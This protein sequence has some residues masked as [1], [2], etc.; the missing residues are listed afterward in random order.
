MKRL[1]LILTV[2]A[3]LAG[4]WAGVS[5][6]MR[7]T[8]SPGTVLLIRPG[9]TTRQI[10]REL[11]AAG[12]I[13]SANGFRLVN[14]LEGRRTLKAGEYLFE[15]PASALEVY[16]RLARGDVMAAAVVIPEG[17]NQWDIAAALEQAGICRREEFLQVS[18]HD[19]SLV[20]DIDPQAKSL[21][22]YLFPDTYHLARS[23]SAREIAGVMV[24]RFRKE[25]GSLGLFGSPTLRRTV[26]L[27]S[28]VEKETSVPEERALVAG[29]FENRLARGIALATDPSVIY[30]AL[31][32]GKYRGVI[33]QSDL[34]RD[35]PYNTYRVAGLPPGPIANPGRAALEAAMHPAQTDYLY[36]VANNQGGHN[37]S[38]TLEE[39]NRH[40]SAYRSGLSK[41]RR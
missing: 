26:I 21:E 14:V 22:G 19:T 1:F 2:A 17:F 40:V 8:P 28:I 35:S 27:A 29:V 39:H 23:Q 36:F 32:E 38:R 7:V 30:A 10:A 16:D 11:E 37:F 13:Q 9:S 18:Q 15:R 3:C 4:A 25:A 20:R 5:V 24:Q 12:V 31:M 41:G 6:F 34:E 33:Y